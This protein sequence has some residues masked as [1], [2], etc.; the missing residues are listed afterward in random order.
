MLAAV[1]QNIG[2]SLVIFLTHFLCLTLEIF[3]LDIFKLVWLGSCRRNYRRNPKF[4]NKSVFDNGSLAESDDWIWDESTSAS[5]DGTGS[6]KL[7]CDG[8]WHALRR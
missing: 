6:I 4:I 7:N 1:S 8:E 2:D 3:W 5:S